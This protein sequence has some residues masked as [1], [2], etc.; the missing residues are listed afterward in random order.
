[1]DRAEQLAIGKKHAGGEEAAER[2]FD[3][4]FEYQS[5]YN[6]FSE[7]FMEKGCKVDGS[8]KLSD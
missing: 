6:M 1:M 7:K 3:F 2:P 5:D 4:N 8:F